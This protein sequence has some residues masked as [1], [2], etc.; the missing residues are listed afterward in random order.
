M[1]TDDKR[2]NNFVLIVPDGVTMPP[3]AVRAVIA[4]PIA[5]EAETVRIGASLGLASAQGPEDTVDALLARADRVLYDA[6]EA[7]RRVGVSDGG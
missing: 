1:T 7:V 2:A 4:A 6:K 5:I 3:E